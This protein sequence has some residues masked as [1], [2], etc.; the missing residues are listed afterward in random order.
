M[1]INITFLGM[2]AV[3]ITEIISSGTYY[4][5]ILWVGYGLF[6]VYKYEV[7]N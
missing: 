2:V 4:S 6:E 7:K 3:T 5:F 1:K